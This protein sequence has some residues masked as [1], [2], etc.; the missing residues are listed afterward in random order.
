VKPA[1]IGAP[2]VAAQDG[3]VPSG[4]LA[5]LSV[6]YFG[7]MWASGGLWNI[8]RWM[9]IFL[10]SY[11]VN[12]LTGSPLAVQLAGT[13]FFLPMFVGGMVAGAVSDRFDRRRT[14]LRQLI[15]LAP[16]AALMALAVGTGAVRVWMLY[17]F[18]VAVGLGQVV[19]MTTRRAL[20]NDLVGDR[21]FGNAMALEALSMAAGN[22]LGSLT[23]GAVIGA[24]GKSAAYGVVAAFYLVCFALMVSVPVIARRDRAGTAAT[25]GGASS[26]ALREMRRDLAAGLRTLPANRPFVSLLGVTA[27]VNFLF[28][29]FM[30]MVPVLARRFEVGPLLT[31][32]LASGLGLGMLIGSL[33]MVVLEPGRR[34]VI[35][36]G[37]ALLAMVL[38]VVFAVLQVFV[39]ALVAL[40]LTG[41]C[42]AG[43]A[44]VQTALVMSVNA[45]EMRGRAMGVLSMAIGTL[46]FGMVLLGALAERMGSHAAVV[47]SA[48]AG[49]V[50]LVGW[51]VWRP[52]VLRIA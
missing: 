45:P 21:L 29:S 34:G 10:G 25:S 23:G 7:R 52:E 46:P 38:L 36:V 5:A 2:G 44:S 19:D 28:F 47:A 14:I 22:S 8:T 18:A 11:L 33:L 42:S 20:V 30:P 12:Q 50:V 40:V 3:P 31:G 32:V 6:R 43:F 15:G 17:V 48:V 16:L 9:T 24:L 4:P 27:I 13:C 1:P 26:D 49:M 41:V 37:G 39:L 35:Y 51:L